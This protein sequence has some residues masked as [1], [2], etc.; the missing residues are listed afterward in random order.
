MRTVRSSKLSL[1]QSMVEDFVLGRHPCERES[2]GTAPVDH[3]AVQAAAKFA[4]VRATGAPVPGAATGGGTVEECVH[5]AGELLLARLERRHADATRLEDE[6]DFGSCDPRWL[7]VIAVYEEAFGHLHDGHAIPYVTYEHMDD[8]VLDV[9]PDDATIALVGDWGTGTAEA[10]AL[11]DRISAH[12]PDVL[13]HLGDVYYSGTPCET[14]ARFLD[15][16]NTILRHS[17][18]V[19]VY[20]LSGNHDMYSGGH[21]YYGLLRLLNDQ[22]HLQPASFFSLRTR[23]GS[24]QLLAMDTGLHDHD[25]FTVTSDVTYLEPAEAAWH[26]DKIER[27]RA[28]GGRTILL[29][30][31]QLFSASEYVGEGTAKP[32]G[33]E[34]YNVKLL[35]TFGDSLKDV[36]AWFWGHEHNL[37][38]YEPY[39]SLDKGRCI[40]H[41]AIPVYESTAP[42]RPNPRIPH[43]PA[44]VAAGGRAVELPERD[45]VYGHG[46]VILELDGRDATARY[47]VDSASDPLYEET[48]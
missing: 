25:P 33:Q 1:V 4:E 41:G 24:W 21:G 10:H 23:S 47:Y 44:L 38:I 40:G 43:P 26:L 39:G 3:P 7:E 45:G 15:P 30:H 28:A 9:L 37:C 29:S 18:K 42:Y 19:P 14:Q 48:I 22:P 46:Y 20:T 32:A 6:L 12:E 27:L 2:S 31:H 16:C 8:F 11:L 34:A 35:E 13:V 5:V 36:A 17:R